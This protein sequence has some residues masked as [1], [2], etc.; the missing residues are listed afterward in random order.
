MDL[1]KNLTDILQITVNCIS[2]GKE[3]DSFIKGFVAT[4][5]EKLSKISLSTF[6]QSELKEK[7]KQCFP[8]KV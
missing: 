2:I 8:L 5:N 1:A 4:L 6:Y 3:K 7:S